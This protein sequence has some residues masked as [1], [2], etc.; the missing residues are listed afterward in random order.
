MTKSRAT[1][2]ESPKEVEAEKGGF[3]RPETGTVP[4][5]EQ[6]WGTWVPPRRGHIRSDI[7]VGL[8]EGI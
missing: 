7:D 1:P 3:T 4:S 6:S 2:D 5:V 8:P